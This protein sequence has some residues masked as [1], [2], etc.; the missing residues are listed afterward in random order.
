MT[1]VGITGAAGRI[2]SMLVDGLSDQYELTLFD[3]DNEVKQ[4]YG[5]DHH[6]VVADLS[7]AEAIVGL[8]DGID[9]VL[10][11][12]ASARDTSPWESVLPHNIVATY[13]VFEEARRAGVGKLVFAS[14]NHTQNGIAMADTSTS[15]TPFYEKRRGYIRLDDPPTPTSIY[16]VSKIF[17]ES[18]GWLYHKRHGI[19]FVG[20]RIGA[21]GP[22]DNIGGSL[23]TD[24]ES[25]I[26]AMFLSRRDCIEVFKRAIEVDTEFLVAYA[27][28]DN[29]GRI[30]DMKESM[31]KLEFDPQDNSE[32]FFDRA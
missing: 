23:G 16:G 26:R 19:R 29:D 3:V 14:S 4:K 22:S 1:T 9:V 10:H 27:I 21:T 15:L 31:E 32:D 25:Y 17:G 2:G 30:F 28:S 20:L 7:D 13:N 6:T 5:D 8:F 12:A 11:L 24:R 18:L